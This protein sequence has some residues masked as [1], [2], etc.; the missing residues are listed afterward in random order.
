[1]S[2]CLKLS[3]RKKLCAVWETS[4]LIALTNWTMLTYQTDIRKNWYM[5]GLAVKTPNGAILFIDLADPENGPVRNADACNFEKLPQ[6][7]PRCVQRQSERKM[8]HA[9][10]GLKF[11]ADAIEAN[12]VLRKALELMQ[13]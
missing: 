2:E 8:G 13:W 4:N 5:N 11:D 10:I 9:A 12:A 1:M 7:A 6:S 3:G